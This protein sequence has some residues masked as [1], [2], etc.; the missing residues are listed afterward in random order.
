MPLT[1]ENAWQLSVE[2]VSERLQTNLQKGLS[3]EEADKRLK[4]YGPNTIETK[5][6]QSLLS[7]F[8]HQFV[9]PL[10]WVLGIAAALAFIFGEWLEA[11]AILAVILINAL[12]GFFMEWQATRSMEALRKMAQIHANVIR[13]GN[14]FRIKSSEL[15][16]GDLLFLDAGDVVPADGRVIE[17]SN[18]KLK[19]AA[20]T[21]ESTS[22]RKQTFALP[23][24]VSLAD[25]N[26]LLFKGT[27]VAAGN[28]K[29]IVTATGKST[30]LGKISHLTEK[31]IKS[32]TPLE[33]KLNVLSQKLLWLTLVLTLVIFAIG[34]VQGRAVYL[35][36]KTAI[37]LG[38]A[39]IPEGLPIIATIAL[40]RGMLR[41]ARHK[42]VVKKLSAVETLGETEV[43]FT[44]KTGTLTENSL[45]TDTLVFEFGQA[46]V[47]FDQQQL[48]F[49]NAK[50]KILCHSFAFEQLQ[51]VAVLCNNAALNHNGDSSNHVGD[52]LEVALLEFAE[53]SGKNVKNLR[54]GYPRLK[55][56]PFDSD[57]KMMGTLHK[58]GKKPN[59]LVCIKGAIEVLLK[60]SDFILTQTGKIPFT[61]QKE[62]IE[63]NNKLS[64]KGLRTLAFAYS[65]IEEP[66][67]HFFH[68][69]IFIGF[70]GFLDP[71]RPEV[72][73]AIQT[74][75]SA[76]IRV[77]MVTGDHPET[78]RNI[79]LKTGL[80]E[81]EHALTI[82]GSNL[83][84]SEQLQDLE[85]EQML[86]TPIF[87]RV[88][89]AQKLNLVS[90]YQNQNQTVGMTG[91]GINDAPAL[92]KADIGIAMGQRGTEAAK[93][94]A[95]L[96]LEDDAF[97]SIVKAIRQGRGIFQNIRYFVV[98][99]LSC[100]LSEILIVAIAAIANFATPLLPL[101]ILFLN[102][103]T[104]VFPALALGMNRE[105][106]NVMN[107]PPRKSRE[108]IINRKMWQHII[109]YAVSITIAVLGILIYAVFYL[110]TSPEIAN[111]LAFYTLILAQLWHVFNLPSASQ[112]FLHNEITQ[113]IHIWL[114]LLTCIVI[115]FL[116]YKIQLIQEV[117]NLH[118]INWEMLWIVIPFSL[119]P[120]GLIQLVKRLN[121]T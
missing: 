114:A 118:E 72:K 34:I 4:E 99:L 90:L 91:D 104:D 102:M 9:S 13:D 79:A 57:S 43:I 27:T 29:T 40:A 5:K 26:N 44:D 25:R 18:L 106:N 78:A 107:V 10:V 101:Q 105:T 70:I 74:C 2:E 87:A 94:V 71:P 73:E 84:S 113:N 8:L 69:L 50:D 95:D 35:M 111:N 15:V 46:N 98:Y 82:H 88:S 93:E 119:L 19:E 37:A 86:Q 110:K 45:S 24:E 109:I 83:C 7:L 108:P 63:K 92:K 1:I 67:E 75:K 60:E 51:K 22:V 103:V 17:Q 39:A 52:P 68:N 41:L 11:F 42:V 76:G 120:I 121:L 96:I 61:N 55:E 36:M 53:K 59:Y 48:Q 30:E 16:P 3:E 56:I 20:L 32:A 58:N 85:L 54:E 81:D 64:K 31:A 117:L 112:S 6:R 49:T 77:V 89:P 33:K 65:E 14:L 47:F 66:S 21:G 38:I 62:W 97:S 28:G 12:I 100:N 115:T 116:A 23:E 80:T